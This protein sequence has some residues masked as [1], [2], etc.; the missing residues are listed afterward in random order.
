MPNENGI[1]EG[2]LKLD[3]G[4]YNVLVPSLAFHKN[5]L[6][7]VKVE[8]VKVNP[9][10]ASGDVYVQ[11][12]EGY[13]ADKRTKTVSLTKRSL[14]NIASAMGINLDPKL[15]RPIDQGWVALE[16]PLSVHHGRRFPWVEFQAVGTARTAD[17][18]PRTLSASYRLDVLAKFEGMIVKSLKGLQKKRDFLKANPGK[19]E[20]WKDK[21]IMVASDDDI[22]KKAVEE[23]D[24]GIVTFLDHYFRRAESG[25][26]NAL[27]RQFA[28]V[29]N[30]YSPDELSR[31]F[32]VPRISFS[33]DQKDPATRQAVIQAALSATQALFP[34]AQP[35]A[36]IGG[37]G[38]PFDHTTGEIVTVPDEARPQRNV[39]EG[40]IAR[41]QAIEAL[42]DTVKALPVEIMPEAERTA[43]ERS[44]PKLSAAQ[45]PVVQDQLTKAVR[46]RIA[47]VIARVAAAPKDVAAGWALK[48]AAISL[49]DAGNFLIDILTAKADLARAAKV[50]AEDAD[51]PDWMKISGK[52][53][54]K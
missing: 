17:G 40:E 38:Q 42:V 53:G 14:M 2:Q 24:D 5:D 48:A 12:S 11:R 54:D 21:Q 6:F 33:P 45:V 9:D 19:A 26:V 29:K 43:F 37:P 50:K 30:E 46:G 7:E 32:A 36:L 44:A 39:D 47:D 51:L 16:N 52:D 41:I 8:S 1:A 31:P 10:P 18:T 3:P 27:V 34:A 28:P 35:Q 23:A 25:A 15:T 20:G 22:R 4:Q 13:G 49:A